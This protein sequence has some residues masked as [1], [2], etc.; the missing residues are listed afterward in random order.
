MSNIMGGG[1]EEGGGKRIFNCSPVL[2]LKHIKK[3]LQFNL[4]QKDYFFL[5]SDISKKLFI[6]IVSLL[7]EDIIDNNIYINNAVQ[8][9]SCPC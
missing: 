3:F 7:R 4:L 8:L 6:L 5:F 9:I 2:S 1:G